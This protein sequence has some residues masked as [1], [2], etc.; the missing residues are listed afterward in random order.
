MNTSSSIQTW[1]SEESASLSVPEFHRVSRAEARVADYTA[2]R[3]FHPALK[4]FLIQLF[5]LPAI[6][7]SPGKNA[8]P[9]FEKQMFDKR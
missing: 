9:N 8:S 4:T 1:R 2:D 3:D 5:S 7:H 6:I